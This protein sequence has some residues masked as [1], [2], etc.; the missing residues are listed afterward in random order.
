MLT[1]TTRRF[2]AA[3]AALAAA[4]AATLAAAPA[5]HAQSAPAPRDDSF[6]VPPSPLPEGKPGDVI[7][8]RASTALA[9]ADRGV[10]A[11]QV[12]YRST[13]ALGQP[14]P[15]V[16]TVLVPRGADPKTAPVVSFAAGTH[17]GSF[18]C[19]VS[20]MSEIGAFYEQSAVNDMLAQGWIVAMTDY[21]GYHPTPKTTYIT[22]RSEGAAVIDM[23]RA[24]QRLPEVAATAS[25][26]MFRGYSQGGG[27][28]LWAGELAKTY[29][30]ELNVVGLVAGGVPADLIQVTLFLEGKFGFGF[31]L[32][33]LHGLDNAYPELDLEKYLNQ[34]G[35]QA[36]TA[37][38]SGDCTLELLVKYQGKRLNEYMTTSPVLTPEWQARVGENKLG[39]GMIDVP[40]FQYHGTLDNVVD[41]RQAKQLSTDY[42][43][44]GVKL[45]W[46]EIAKD[47]IAAIYHGNADALAFMKDR[48]AGVP[49]TT[50]C[51]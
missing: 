7:R 16:G 34:T 21:E 43:A 19:R 9:V 5:G 37:M 8:S 39:K 32:Y 45:T 50:T 48:F 33:A 18:R 23:V 30:P 1:T 27:A 3:C 42:C 40:V 6:Y 36:M 25:K 15:V 26:V 35:V 28:S 29:A 49:A 20:Y 13:N 22:G 41:F 38:N 4:L 14:I 46:K 17:G 2:A 44:K 24:T 12:M 51:A 47:H 10:K 11:W 31:L